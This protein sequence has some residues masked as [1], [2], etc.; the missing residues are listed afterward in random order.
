MMITLQSKSA[1]T[2]EKLMKA[3]FQNK[4]CCKTLTLN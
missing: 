1:S 2:Q 3:N 4:K